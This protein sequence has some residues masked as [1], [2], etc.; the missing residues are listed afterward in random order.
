MPDPSRTYGRGNVL[1]SLEYIACGLHTRCVLRILGSEIRRGVSVFVTVGVRV[2]QTPLAA[3]VSDVGKR[4]PPELWGG[5]TCRH[6]T[7]Q[8]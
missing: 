8:R 6:A 5:E 4:S 2:R 3:Q 7:L 1:Y